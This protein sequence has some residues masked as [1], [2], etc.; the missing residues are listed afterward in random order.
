[1][2]EN[3][4]VIEKDEFDKTLR[5]TVLNADVSSRH[6]RIISI[7][8]TSLMAIGA[9]TWSYFYLLR[10]EEDTLQKD[11]Q[12]Y[13]RFSLLYSDATLAIR[14][15]NASKEALKGSVI[16][17]LNLA[18]TNLRQSN[19]FMSPYISERYTALVDAL[20]GLCRL[21]IEKKLDLSN[22]EDQAYYNQQLTR[23][24]TYYI[25]Y[26][27]NSSLE[28]LP[29]LQKAAVEKEMKEAN[30]SPGAV[31]QAY[32]NALKRKLDSLVGKESYTIMA[33]AVLLGKWY[34][35]F[36]DTEN[37]QRCFEIAR[38]YV[39]G[40]TML[41]VNYSGETPKELGPAWD[42]YV[43]AVSALAE[44][45]SEK[46]SYRLARSYLARIFKTPNTTVSLGKSK[47]Q[48][49]QL[50][51]VEEKIQNLQYDIK[52]VGLAIQD[53]RSIQSF[54]LFQDDQRT[55]I[56]P[57]LLK[58]L[59]SM[60]HKEGDKQP[61][62]M[63]WKR[64]NPNIQRFISLGEN[65][66]NLS[67]SF[68]YAI[69]EGLNQLVILPSFYLEA[70]YNPD[71]LV[72]HS[73]H[74]LKE[75][76]TRDLTPDEYAF[77]NRDI[78]D[79]TFGDSLAKF[80]Q[81]SN[82]SRI[83]NKL[84][85]EKIKILLDIYRDECAQPSTDETRVGEL[86]RR[87]FRIENGKYIPEINDYYDAIENQIRYYSAIDIQ[88]EKEYDTQR[89]TLNQM[90]F[91]FNEFEIKGTLDANASNELQNQIQLLGYKQ[92]QILITKGEIN[93]KLD[94]LSGHLAKVGE[95]LEAS[96][97]QM[98]DRLY[99]LKTIQQNIADKQ[100][101]LEGTVV[102]QL[103]KHLNLRKKYLHTLTLIKD[104]ETQKEIARLLEEKNILQA[105]IS[106][107]KANLPFL[108]DSS[109]ELAQLY[110][111][112]LQKKMALIIKQ[113]RDAYAPLSSAID[114][115][116][117]EES[118]GW[119]LQEQLSQMQRQIYD[120]I[121][122]D[123]QPGSLRKMMKEREELLGHQIQE[124]HY[125][126]AVQTRIDQL[127]Q[128]IKEGQT[129][130]EELIE[131]QAINYT[132]LDALTP[133][134]IQSQR[135]I[136]KESF[137][138]LYEKMKNISSSIEEYSL[139]QSHND[140]EKE[141]QFLHRTII[142][143]FKKIFE[144]T[145]SL[146]KID[147]NST[148]QVG[149]YMQNIIQARQNL[150]EIE[151]KKKILVQSKNLS[152]VLDEE[153]QNYGT[154]LRQLELFQLESE[155]GFH[156]TEF[157]K[158]FS[159]RSEISKT[160]QE[161]L[162][163][164]KSLEEQRVE[165]LKGRDQ[166]QLD[167]IQPEIS[168]LEVRIQKLTSQ[169]AEVDKI[170]TNLV[171]EYQS[172]YQRIF[173]YQEKVQA[174]ANAVNAALKKAQEHI[175][176][177][178]ATL[179]ALSQKIFN[180]T[181]QTTSI[182]T[183]PGI[184]SSGDL[185]ALI[186]HE[187]EEIAHLEKLYLLSQRENF[188][189][190]KAIWSIAR[191]Y[192]AQA[193]LNDYE[194]LVA[195]TSLPAIVQQ[196]EQRLLL[197]PLFEEFDTQFIYTDNFL[198]KQAEAEDQNHANYLA[199][200][201]FLE[202]SAV[203]LYQEELP[204]YAIVDS[205]LEPGDYFK[206]KQF[207]DNILF[208]ADSKYNIA[209]IYMRRSHRFVRGIK[210]PYHKSKQIVQELDLATS[211]LI[212]FLDFSSRN[213]RLGNAIGLTYERESSQE[214]PDR[215]RY[216]YQR[217]D[218][219]R[220]YLG[221]IAY[222]KKNPEVAIENLE[223]LLKKAVAVTQIKGLS[224]NSNLPIGSV[225]E[226]S[227]LQYLY[228]HFL[229][230][231]YISMLSSRPVLVEAVFRL[232]KS[233][234]EV[235]LRH[236]HNAQTFEKSLDARS[237][238]KN[239]ELDLMR[240]AAHRAVAYYSQIIHTQ[241]YSEYRQACLFQRAM[242][243]KLLGF[244]DAAQQDLLTALGQASTV[245]ASTLLEDC[246]IKGDIPSDLN[247]SYSKLCFELGSI[248]LESQDYFSAVEILKEANS[249]G[250]DKRELANA[251]IAYAKALMGAKKWNHANH[252]LSK[253]LK[254][255]AALSEK[256]RA[257]YPQ[258]LYLLL[259]TT[260]Q[261][262]VA[263]NSATSAF[264]EVFQCAPK[265]LLSSDGMLIIED[266]SGID[267]L[268][269]D[270]RD[271]IRPLSLASM[272]LGDI[273]FL[274]KGFYVARSHYK[275][276][277]FL[278]RM[279]RWQEDPEMSKLSK[280]EFSNYKQHL[281]L[282]S[283]W[284]QL[285]CDLSELLF[286][287]MSNLHKD[288]ISDQILT[289]KELVKRQTNLVQDII[290]EVETQRQVYIQYFEKLNTFYQETFDSLPETKEANLIAERRKL[291]RQQLDPS[292]KKYDAL[293]RLRTLIME[294]TIADPELFIARTKEVYPIG[295]AEGNLLEEFSLYL[296]EVIKLD[297]ADRIA[298]QD[299]KSNFD[300]LLLLPNRQERLKI[301]FPQLKRWLALQLEISGLNEDYLPVSKQAAILEEVDLYRVSFLASIGRKEDYRQ[302]REI[303]D[304][305][306]KSYHT[307]PN[308]M[309]NIEHYFALL[310]LGSL[311][312][313]DQKEW[314]TI[315]RYNRQLLLPELSPFFIHKGKSDLLRCKV[316]L[317]NA[318]IEMSD[319]LQN[320]ITPEMEKV[321]RVSIERNITTKRDEAKTILLDAEK[322]AREAETGKLERIRAAQLLQR[323]DR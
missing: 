89:S 275:K 224:I 146:K 315:E 178:D 47:G 237:F 148:E 305:Y 238:R 91:K 25:E 94:L 228:N 177:N 185:D 119:E 298:F 285:K 8:I 24:G 68:R 36:N 147:R 59:A 139:I 280:D 206:E 229:D 187:E 15:P 173:L 180:Q 129:V 97:K 279:L 277:L 278:S 93:K 171:N 286:S 6:R 189:K 182:T 320:T 118:R 248:A 19:K 96:H 167:Q 151:N 223:E 191:T 116:A 106:E 264:K 76:K 257:Y 260:F 35:Y 168:T 265:P 95:D 218:Q 242:L 209:E 302:L 289:P 27:E 72:P 251:K 181:F 127:N 98:T 149:R 30:S 121:G 323:I 38:K 60:P 195:S 249:R 245:G 253:L 247:P 306:I 105:E 120:L 100:I 63:L 201:D 175:I 92:K 236:Y 226:T 54:P 225:E 319:E 62:E 58:K 104:P 158:I 165:V 29:L 262:M 85:P 46:K 34:R 51:E 135:P 255:R 66:E 308:R 2:A 152:N 123:D 67:T 294:N 316:S 194:I 267:L 43:E 292:I 235:S 56:W 128:A 246:S 64:L 186:S 300:N 250:L 239:E 317:A 164:R 244:F 142:D 107:K 75:I 208:L 234:Q 111:T 210:V 84:S 288:I 230:P 269:R 174:K 163:A 74:L 49:S 295:T 296:A 287:S 53:P 108:H 259:G 272:S 5:G 276:A 301:L 69:I 216:P 204:K 222:L 23:L 88:M 197:R 183:L 44:I 14:S 309:I 73:K 102:Q 45:A 39:D 82:G 130:F 310:E 231:D 282:S 220:L 290:S 4:P 179:E 99:T 28:R 233:Y 126:P 41:N 271:S 312:A 274:Q 159:K 32:L 291:L 12:D 80:L 258:E 48:D 241:A 205:Q 304:R 314:P 61:L 1:M 57:S 42:E 55:I 284:G 112:E 10:S 211:A 124:G 212:Q 232:A 125:T 9:C 37:A 33:P 283:K 143:N 227:T 221:L 110:L 256:E 141:A 219:A 77:I 200:L 90:K 170:L 243:Y 144:D 266:D 155:M 297:N 169:L 145:Q 176:E 50:A 114:A 122:S 16:Q 86:N 3:K 199:W 192:E 215:Q 136:S 156:V 65:I 133:S 131:A 166:I 11:L 190:A 20:E 109:Q 188:Y 172:R 207:Y 132:M 150:D 7:A 31:S 21:I 240:T 81:L 252:F 261:E 202:K 70:T 203:R 318:L 117:L 293:V 263:Y 217:D 157:R 321:Q 299:D 18:S 71:I 101:R 160:L 184:N 103:G 322:I 134:G 140:L 52:I 113:I 214:F 154:Y 87:I 303:V 138:T 213:A 254:E 193:Q 40:Y 79:Q 83:S 313:E 161:A 26:Y 268:E 198:G 13:Q 311:A 281:I 78:I 153:N 307:A 22:P 17:L 115:I 270:Y 137:L 273:A 196:D 162:E